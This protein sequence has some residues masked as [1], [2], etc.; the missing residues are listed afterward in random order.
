MP[1]KE[2]H[3]RIET[4]SARGI[5]TLPAAR[6]P[7]RQSVFL[8]NMP[9]MPRATVSSVAH[10]MARSAGLTPVDIGGIFS[11][12]KIS[13]DDRE[14][15]NGTE[16]YLSGDDRTLDDIC[17]H[18][19]YLYFGFDELPMGFSQRFIYVDAAALLTRDPR[20]VIVAQYQADQSKAKSHDHPAALPLDEY[21]LNDRVVSRIRHV[22]DSYL[23][24]IRNGLRL[25]QFEPCLRPNR[26]LDIVEM[27][28]KL[29]KKLPQ[30]LHNPQRKERRKDI[31]EETIRRRP[32]VTT[33]TEHY[34]HGLYESLQPETQTKL[35]E[36]LEM[37]LLYLG[38]E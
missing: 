13:F 24:P 37:Q 23:A 15:H 19:G 38:Y 36:I 3:F 11:R 35:N 31:L 27:A 2:D 32:S 28:E 33:I 21:V 12:L 25:V 4:F 30:Y 17:A 9:Q 14:R 22:C 10:T 7:T 5:I 20:D 29:A 8:F 18:G 34:A 1:S 26:N 16:L 6:S